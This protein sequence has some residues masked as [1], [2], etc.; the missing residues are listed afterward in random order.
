V[1]LQF[2]SRKRYHAR[3]VLRRNHDLRTRRAV[4]N[5]QR[6]GSVKRWERSEKEEGGEKWECV[7]H[8]YLSLC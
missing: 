8:D 6:L 1:A 5:E 4:I 7:F 2:K 3:S